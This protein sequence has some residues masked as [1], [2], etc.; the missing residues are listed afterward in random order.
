MERGQRQPGTGERGGDDRRRLAQLTD[1]TR[2]LLA[3]A[4]IVGRRF[5]LGL[6][7][8]V[9]GRDEDCTLELLEGA[10]GRGLLVEMVGGSGEFAFVHALVREVLLSGMGRTRKARLHLRVAEALEVRFSEGDDHP[11]AE[12]ARHFL[13]A[14]DAAGAGKAARYAEAAGV[15]ALER[16][17]Y[18]QAA[19]F[20]QSALTALERDRS[21]DPALRGRLHVRRGEALARAGRMIDARASFKEAV[22]IGSALKDGLLVADAARGIGE[23][24]LNGGSPDAELLAALAL[25]IALLGSEHEA[26][27]THLGGR[28]AAEQRHLVPWDERDRL[29]AAALEQA[30]GGWG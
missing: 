13:A 14:G 19:E 17:G 8:A 29:T 15:S 28:L 3:V 27:R 4:A 30:A 12:L 22:E 26:L 9:S 21:G 11:A 1:A 20:F 18:R 10:A 7:S 24:W 25:A 16:L 2:E 23:G 6:L 5:E